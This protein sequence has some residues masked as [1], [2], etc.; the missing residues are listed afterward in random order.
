M[1]II[2][3]KLAISKLRKTNIK[4]LE[5]LT[6]LFVLLLSFGI[7]N[8][9]ITYYQDT[10]KGSFSMVGASSGD[11]T[12]SITLPT[13]F[14][15]NTSLDKIYLVCYGGKGFHFTPT[16]RVFGINGQY[17]QL[18]TLQ[19]D[20]FLVGNLIPIPYPADYNGH[21][22]YVVDLTSYIS[23]MDSLVFIDWS[24]APMPPDL[25]PGCNISSPILF[26]VHK[27]NT[28]PTVN[29]ALVIN[30]QKNA[31]EIELVSNNLNLPD[32][33]HPIALGIHSDRLGWSPKDGYSFKIN[34]IDA[35]SIEQ[36]DSLTMA[37]GAVG[38]FHYSNSSVTGLTDDNPDS[39]FSGPHTSPVR[40]DGLATIN[41]YISNN[42]INPLHFKFKYM[43][44]SGQDNFF[45]SY[46]LAYSTPCS[47][48][49]VTVTKDTTICAGQS[50]QLNTTGGQ[51][52][53]WRSATTTNNYLSCTDCANPI[54]SGDT[55]TIY[56]VRIWSTDNCSVVRPVQVTVLPKLTHRMLSLTMRNALL[57]NQESS[58]LNRISKQINI[59]QLPKMV[60]HS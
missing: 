13:G 43:L 37:Y 52:Y 33:N 32:Y 16:K 39:I 50:L 60:I 57:H 40:A 44:S 58:L 53:E 36:H 55:T 27:D 15:D 31:F 59:M 48:I 29:A 47:P 35:G 41:S 25:C 4:M 3:T 21:V 11:A 49:D 7:S 23:T 34:N 45:I 56:T 1:S 30:D 10:F 51:R 14:H 12:N 8:A 20:M 28:L 38:C 24:I 19:K 2:L 22:T 46:S 17:F 6:L 5:K 26:M 42:Q 9:Q 18:D 54:F